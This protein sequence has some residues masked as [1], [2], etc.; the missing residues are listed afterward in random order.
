M[1]PWRWAICRLLASGA[2]TIGSCL[3]NAP[4]FFRKTHSQTTAPN[5]QSLRTRDEGVPLDTVAKETPRPLLCVLHADA[6]RFT[7]WNVSAL[8]DSLMKSSSLKRSL[9]FMPISI[10]IARV[11]SPGPLVRAQTCRTGSSARRRTA[12]AWPSS[13][14]TTFKQ[15]YMAD[16]R[17]SAQ[18]AQKT[19]GFLH[20][21]ALSITMLTPDL[22]P[23]RPKER[24]L[25]CF[26]TGGAKRPA[27]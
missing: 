19:R 20:T 16:F 3:V 7:I 11:S 10:A 2:S 1:S 14:V 5:P 4:H 6:R 22:T 8:A 23:V 15:K 27:T 26:R 12:E 13:S 24:P 17:S 21:P 25:R 9:P 18:K